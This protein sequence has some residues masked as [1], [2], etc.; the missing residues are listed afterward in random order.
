MLP[1]PSTNQRVVA[2]AMPRS[3]RL[4]QGSPIDTRQYDASYASQ[5]R[6]ALTPPLPSTNQQVATQVIPCAPPSA[7]SAKHHHETLMNNK[8]GNTK[9]SRTKGA[10]KENKKTN[11]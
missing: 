7:T 1:L 11:N 3:E 8:P 4:D 6:N 5:T 2:R 9:K 10:S